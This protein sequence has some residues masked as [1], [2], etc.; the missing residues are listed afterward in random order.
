MFTEEDLK[1]RLASLQKDLQT[2]NQLVIDT[3]SRRDQVIGQLLLV[4]DLLNNGSQDNK[5][6]GEIQN[7]KMESKNSK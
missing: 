6:G 1:Q 2:L 7:R 3:T 5:Q 4:Q